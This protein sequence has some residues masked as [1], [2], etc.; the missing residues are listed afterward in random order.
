ML[1][2]WRSTVLEMA[3][4]LRLLRIKSRNHHVKLCFTFQLSQ[5][6]FQWADAWITVQ[7][8]SQGRMFDGVTGKAVPW[9]YLS[10]LESLVYVA[11][12]YKRRIGQMVLSGVSS[13]SF[14]FALQS[15]KP[16]KGTNQ[17]R[18]KRHGSM[19]DFTYIEGF[20][21]WWGETVGGHCYV[22]VVPQIQ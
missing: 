18:D 4:F 2:C 11:L 16:M 20:D 7:L 12:G 13:S 1:H 5:S 3:L 15:I 8:K 22:S 17:I 14:E 21:R 6:F 9:T 19:L 10:L